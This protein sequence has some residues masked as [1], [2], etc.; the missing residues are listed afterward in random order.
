MQVP[1]ETRGARSQRAG[2]AGGCGLPYAGAGYCNQVLWKGSL[3]SP[4]PS[5]KYLKTNL[6]RELKVLYS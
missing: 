6:A 1:L 5:A 3:H 4:D 2:D